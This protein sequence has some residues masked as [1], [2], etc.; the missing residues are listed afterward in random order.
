MRSIRTYL[1]SRLLGG[2]ALVLFVAGAVVYV[3]AGRALERQFDASL[4]DRAQSFASMLFQVRDEVEFEFSGELMPEFERA[5]DPA[6]FQIWFDDAELL[7]RSDSLGLRDLSAPFA[8]GERASFWTAALPDGR[9]GRFVGQTLEIHHVYPEEG[10]GRPTARVVRVIVA[11]SRA[12]LV[13]ATLELLAI[14]AGAGLTLLALLGGLAWR[15]VRRGLAPAQRMARALDS[16]RVEELPPR[17][18][19]DSLPE[20]LRPVAD[21]TDALLVRIQSAMERERRTT[22]DIAH[23]LRTPISEVLTVSEVALRGDHALNGSR[24]AL[25]TVREVAGRMA[26]TVTTLLKLSRLQMG[27]ERFDLREVELLPLLLELGPSLSQLAREREVAIEFDVPEGLAVRGD[28]QVISI[29][30]SN[31]LA[32]ALTYAPR[33]SSVDVVA[34]GADAGWSLTVANE[35]PELEPTDLARLDEPFWRKD[36]ARADRNRSGLGLALSRALAEAAG[37]AL[38][39]ELAEGRFLARVRA[40]RA[41]VS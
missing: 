36:R 30:V 11:R 28:R 6:Y 18:E 33:D 17:L 37:L 31:L 27:A 15:S 19:L 10:P 24:S 29:V 9:D 1:L 25:E 21:T 3:V 22:A 2:A 38:D 12:P 26:R 8:L 39:F 16:I 4:Q 5:E 34:A 41:E 20:E 13:R 32:N 7:E 35:A 14:C 40:R 23:E